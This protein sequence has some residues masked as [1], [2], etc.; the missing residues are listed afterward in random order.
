MTL[1][2]SSKLL[3]QDVRALVEA[4]VEA[5][6]PLRVIL[7]GSHARGS[8]DADSDVDLLIVQSEA[9]AVHRSRWRELQRIRA[10]VRNLPGAK[11]LLL[12]RPA[13]FD[14]W[15]RSPNHVVGRAVREG[16]LLYER[17]Q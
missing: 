4:I 5:A 11:D 9:D 16:I 15:C 8:A 6:H 13:E 3:A 1:T 12:Y 14:Y 10:A 7:F 17:P 2:L